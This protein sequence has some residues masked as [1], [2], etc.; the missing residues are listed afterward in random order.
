MMILKVQL[1]DPNDVQGEIDLLTADE[2]HLLR[3]IQCIHFTVI[4]IRRRAQR[5]LQ[6]LDLFQRRDIAIEVI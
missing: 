4:R 2:A 5:P 6:A 1:E 3:S